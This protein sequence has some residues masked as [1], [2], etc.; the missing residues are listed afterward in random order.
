MPKPGA[1]APEEVT[2]RSRLFTW[3]LLVL[4]PVPIV[5]YMVIAELFLG[6][7]ESARPEFVLAYVGVVLI[8]A[9]EYLREAWNDH[10]EARRKKAHE[11]TPL[12]PTG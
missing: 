9:W 11:S 5:A 7:I 6:G 12:G 8:L 4:I 10:R 3:G 2:W 1:T